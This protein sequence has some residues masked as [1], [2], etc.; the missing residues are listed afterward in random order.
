[1][2]SGWLFS[3]TRHIST[4]SLFGQYRSKLDYDIIGLYKPLISDNHGIILQIS[5]IWRIPS[6]PRKKPGLSSERGRRPLFRVSMTSTSRQVPISVASA[7]PRYSTRE[8]S[9]KP[10][11]AG[12]L[13]TPVSRV[14]SERSSILMADGPRSAAPAVMV[15][16]ATSSEAKAIRLPTPGTASIRFPSALYPLGSRYHPYLKL[17]KLWISVKTPPEGGE[18]S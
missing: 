13:L 16:S 9:S 2:A 11:A 18:S 8:P 1:M 10:A 12:Q 3:A 7:M 17:N 5:H 4:F 15:I 14:Q 6:S